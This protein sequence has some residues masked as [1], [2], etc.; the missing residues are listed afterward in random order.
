[1]LTH[2]EESYILT[3]AYVPEHVVGLMTYLSGGEPFL[4]ENFFCCRKK[5]WIIVVGYP[6][7]REFSLAEFEGVVENLKNQ[8]RPKNISIIAPQILPSLLA[9]STENESDHYYTLA[10]DQFVLRS[11][12][13]RNLKK[14][15][16]KLSVE[17]AAS[18]QADHEKLMGEFVERVKPAERVKNLFYKMPG[19]VRHSDSA[20]VLNAW[21]AHKHLAAF[22][23]VDLA[24]RDFSNYIIGCYSKQNY[25]V[26][27][28]D[29]LLYELIQ[30]SKAHQKNYL[31]LGLGVNDGIRRF[32]EKWGAKPTQP[33]E[34]CEI[35]LKKPSIWDAIRAI[36]EF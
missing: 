4:I 12:V 34:M 6:L 21:D 18:M 22:Y 32:K 36:G 5:D 20:W 27:A 7:E 17:C 15:R 1:M 9:T 35:A 13:R 10:V 19:F 33:Y 8:F 28:S 3:R 31:H 2:K 25:I 29:L 23:V 30:L 11:A 24:A 26:G 16:E 14:A